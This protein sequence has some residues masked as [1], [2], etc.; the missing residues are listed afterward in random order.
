MDLMARGGVRRYLDTTFPEEYRPDIGEVNL[1]ELSLTG[2]ADL[3]GS[4]KGSIKH[5]YTKIYERV[6]QT[7]L[8]NVDRI[9]ASLSLCEFGVA[10]GASL[11]MWANYLPNSN[12]YGFDV[13][14]E[15][16]KLC[17]DLSNVKIM[18]SDP[19]F[20]DFGDLSFDLV[21]EDTSHISE[22]IVD[23][24]KNCWRAVK[25]G[26]FYI[27]EDLSCTYDPNYT[28]QFTNTFKRQVINDRS[29]VLNFLDSVMR[30]V[31]Q[32]SEIAYFEY[33]P[34]MLLVRKFSKS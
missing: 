17:D 16:A 9:E 21:V 19:R 29:T 26:G 33:H 14:D 6:V 3:Y 30:Y 24:F 27:V 8:G 20:H 13:R 31:D 25:P 22:D 10:C 18:I 5:R 34:Q 12:V 7:L 2:L 32:R 23:I 1:T 28:T 15:C 11:R 4:D